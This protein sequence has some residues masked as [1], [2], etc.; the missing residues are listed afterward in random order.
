MQPEEQVSHVLQTNIAI[1]TYLNHFSS[2]YGAQPWAVCAADQF[3]RI[4]QLH[5]YQDG[6]VF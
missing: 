4:T 5:I 3:M 6:P 1:Y 2:Y